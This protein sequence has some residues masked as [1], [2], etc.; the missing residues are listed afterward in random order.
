MESNKQTAVEWLYEQL[1]IRMKNYLQEELIKAK[2]M[3]REQIIEAFKHGELPPP[4]VNFNAD[5][6]YE[7]TYKSNGVS[8]M[9]SQ[10]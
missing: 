1:P 9:G 4:F 10:T 3:E 6:Y 7:K 2:A 8:T 5:E